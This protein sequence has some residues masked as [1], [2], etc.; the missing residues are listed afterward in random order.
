MPRFDPLP[1]RREELSWQFISA[2]TS[3]RISESGATLP[4]SCGPQTTHRR[5]RTA[6]PTGSGLPLDAAEASADRQGSS[7]L[8]FRD[9]RDDLHDVGLDLNTIKLVYYLCEYHPTREVARILNEREIPATFGGRWNAARV[10]DLLL[11]ARCFALIG[12]EAWERTQ[13]AVQAR[14]NT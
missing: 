10:S 4:R 11:D 5:T 9:L 1:E 7:I 14:R 3:S 12:Q 2:P 13:L 8:T 6:Y